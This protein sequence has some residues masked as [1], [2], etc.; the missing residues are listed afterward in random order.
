MAGAAEISRETVANAAS[1][2]VLNEVLIQLLLIGVPGSGA[3]AKVW[4]IH[5]NVVVAQSVL[6]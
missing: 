6:N 3:L 1:P 4:E 2:E 5:R